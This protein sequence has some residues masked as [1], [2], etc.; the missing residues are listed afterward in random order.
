MTNQKNIFRTTGEKQARSI[1]FLYQKKS[2]TLKFFASA[3][4]TLTLKSN[5]FSVKQNLLPTGNT[6]VHK[7]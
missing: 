3:T 1:G 4:K 7:V 6:Y 5:K 2:K